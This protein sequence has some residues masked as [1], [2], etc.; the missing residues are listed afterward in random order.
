FWKKQ[1]QIQYDK[2]QEKVTRWMLQSIK[3]DM[4]LRGLEHKQI[5]IFL[6][7]NRDK[8]GKTFIGQILA[9]KLRSFKINTVLLTPEPQED[10][11]IAPEVVVDRHYV[12]EYQ[13]TPDF[14]HKQEV[15]ELIPDRGIDLSAYEFVLVELPALLDNPYPMAM[16]TKGDYTF[17]V[18]RANRTWNA[19]DKTLLEKLSDPLEKKPYL[20][21]NGVQEDLLE[22]M[23]GD[24]PKK[25][26]RIRR[27]LKRFISL[28]FKARSSI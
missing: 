26:S 22:G 2:L 15:T 7:S 3:S 14:F 28:G 16:L 4:N 18:G 9:E 25:R 23:I 19:A 27:V 12:H 11:D 6:T 13:I 24:I 1:P 5:T 10:E 21:I 8:E 17:I 20:I